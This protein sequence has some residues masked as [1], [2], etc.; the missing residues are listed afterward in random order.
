MFQF[1]DTNWCIRGVSFVC[2]LF[3][4]AKLF[5]GENQYYLSR[6]VRKP[7][8]GCICENKE[9]DQLHDY[10]KALFFLNLKIHVS[11]HL[12]WLYSSVVSDLVRNPEDWL[13]QNKAHLSLGMRKP[14]LGVSVLETNMF[15]DK[16]PIK[17][18]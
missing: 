17:I 15:P 8:V 7:A 9:A 14:F 11:S 3:D 1:K 10:S 13:S 2:D 4:L 6:I 5:W 12:L 16:N 18:L